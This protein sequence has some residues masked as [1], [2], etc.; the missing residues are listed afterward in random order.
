[1]ACYEELVC[2]TGSEH[3]HPH[4]P[5][6]D[7]NGVNSIHADAINGMK[8]R[9]RPTILSAEG[10]VVPCLTDS[11]ARFHTPDHV[12]SRELLVF[13]TDFRAGDNANL[14]QLS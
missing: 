11:P 9:Q 13:Q 14:P 8:A 7:Y 1:M 6:S 5:R 4:Q 2:P 12:A 10:H 3:F